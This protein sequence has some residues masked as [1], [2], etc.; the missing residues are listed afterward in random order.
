MNPE[1][2][3]RVAIVT[4]AARGIGAEIARQLASAGISVTV[5]YSTSKQA[6]E[7]VVASIKAAGGKAVAVQADM[8]D[9]AQIDKLFGATRSAF[10]VASILI[11]NAGMAGFA[12]IEEV[13]AQHIDEQFE[14]NVRAVALA[15]AAFV[16]QFPKGE[17]LNDARIVN[18][19]SFVAVQPMSNATIYSATKGAIDTLTQ[20]LA[21]E[22]GPR[23]IRVNAVAPGAIDTDMYQAT[24]KAFEDYLKGRTPL[25][26][27]GQP[28]DIASMV[29]YLCSAQA[30]WITGQIFTV[31]GGI[32]V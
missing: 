9:P 13:N 4:G 8:R 31:N 30:A 25:G 20:G 26:T 12:P 10:G 3:S 5:N 21:Q 2:T 28:K 16:K 32:R 23:G 27:I 22:L 29:S 24:G 17:M 14:L 1:N 19:S 6:A 15:C 7:A 11:N 18:I